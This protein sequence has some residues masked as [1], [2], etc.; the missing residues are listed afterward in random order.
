MSRIQNFILYFLI[1]SCVSIATGEI[2]AT[3]LVLTPLGSS[4]TSIISFGDEYTSSAELYD[5]SI[6]VEKVIRGIP[7]LEVL[8]SSGTEIKPPPDGTE[9]LLTRIKFEY[10][11]RSAPGDRIYHLRK[12]QFI[13]VAPDGKKY[14]PAADIMMPSGVEQGLHAP[15][16]VEGWIAYCVN[17]GDKKLKLVFHEETD[18]TLHRGDGMWFSL[19]K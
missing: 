16:T 5:V 9:Y 2:H 4:Y 15:E 13:V 18:N 17:P 19:Y 3:E 7:A 11:A 12:R 6:T 8:Q 10:R 14:L 1:V